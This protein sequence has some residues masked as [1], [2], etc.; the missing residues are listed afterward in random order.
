MYVRAAMNLRVFHQ[1]ES[2]MKAQVSII[3]GYA[4][5]RQLAKR[6]GGWKSN[7]VAEDEKARGKGRKD[8]NEKGQKGNEEEKEKG[9][10][11]EEEEEEEEEKKLN[12][13]EEYEEEKE[14]KRYF[15]TPYQHRE[16]YVEEKE[17]NVKKMRKERGKAREDV[18]KGEKSVKKMTGLHKQLSTSA[19]SFRTGERCLPPAESE[20]KIRQNDID[21]L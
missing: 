9:I 4:I 6:H 11:D 17:E 14:E 20:R 15:T 12:D 8:W 1:S 3:L 16:E 10:E 2:N 19:R 21:L 5:E 7:T 13:H 18:E